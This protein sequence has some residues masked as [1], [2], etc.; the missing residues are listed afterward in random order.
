M[1]T[2]INKAM[3]KKDSG[4]TLIELLVV[5]III[6]I[7]A[8]IAIPTFLSQRD[9][10]REAGSKADLKSLATEV[11][12]ALTDGVP[13]ADVAIA[14]DNSA[15]TTTATGTFVV[16]GETYSFRVSPG[17]NVQGTITATTGAYCLEADHASTGARSWEVDSA[18]GLA[19]GA[20]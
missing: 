12:S 20:C 15:A 17:Q 16:N 11:E 10:G 6:G 8:A 13:A 19:L 3:A 2:R 1:L 7:L 5:M 9:K 14:L 4:F 18:T